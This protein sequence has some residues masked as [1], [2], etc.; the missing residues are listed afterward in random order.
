PSRRPTLDC[1]LTALS[2]PP[3]FSRQ[4]VSVCQCNSYLSSE[5]VCVCVCS[6]CVCVCVQSGC[7]CVCV[8][9]CSQ[10]VCVSQCSQ[11]VCV[12]VWAVEVFIT[13]VI[14]QA[15]HTHTHTQHTTHV[16]SDGYH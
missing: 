6:Q 8:R 1:A 3:S 9:V 4:Q 16:I 13:Q 15:I 2:H 5:G 12:S 11:G 7:V 14:L 10:G